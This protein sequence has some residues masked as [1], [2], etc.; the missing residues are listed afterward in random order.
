V[1]FIIVIVC[2]IIFKRRARAKAARENGGYTKAEL[3][4]EGATPKPV[5]EIS[6]ADVYEA[7][8]G[9]NVHEKDSKP[10]KQP[11]VELPAN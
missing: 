4:G 9:A 10:V 8:A 6:G 5:A 1:L 7:D 11:P 3:S 2:F